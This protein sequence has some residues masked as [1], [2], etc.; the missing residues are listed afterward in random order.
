MLE[1]SSAT[2]VRPSAESRAGRSAPG[3][4]RTPRVLL[5][6]DEVAIL[7]GFAYAL[8]DS[9]FYILAAR[10][11][12]MGRC[13]VQGAPDVAVVDICGCGAAAFAR[14]LWRSGTPVVTLGCNE[15]S[16]DAPLHLRKP[17]TLP[18]LRNALHAVV[19]FQP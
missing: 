7:E 17:V 18:V 15:P 9:G 3:V 4:A 6:E 2:K 14:E 13:L 11:V 19:R 16:G 10:D 8:E 1:V 5:V 12:T